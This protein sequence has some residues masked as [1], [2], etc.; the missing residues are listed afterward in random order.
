M[1]HTVTHTRKKAGGVNGQESAK[2]HGPPQQK[3]PKSTG[4]RYSRG[5]QSV[6]KDRETCPYRNSTIINGPDSSANAR[7]TCNIQ[8]FYCVFHSG[9]FCV[10][11]YLPTDREKSRDSGF[12]APESLGSYQPTCFSNRGL[13]FSAAISAF[14]WG[15]SPPAA[16]HSPL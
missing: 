2:D 7:N 14:I 6:G 5:W 13:S 15:S 1:T 11:T 8:H 4:K 12:Y 10:T 16:A 9:T 3:C